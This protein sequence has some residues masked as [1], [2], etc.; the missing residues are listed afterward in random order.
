MDDCTRAGTEGREAGDHLASSAAYRDRYGI[1][2]PG[3]LGAPPEDDAQK[4]DAARAGSAL[5]RARSLAD[6]EGQAQEHVRRP[7]SARVGPTL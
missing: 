1:T 2:E 3:P 6:A 5:D 7:G 4:V